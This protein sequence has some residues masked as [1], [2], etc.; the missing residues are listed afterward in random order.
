MQGKSVQAH[1]VGKV[2]EILEAVSSAEWVGEAAG[3]LSVIAARARAAVVVPAVKAAVAVCLAMSVILVV[4]KLSMAAV[5]MLVK[6]LKRKP[7]KVYEWRPISE[8]VEMGGSLA[9]P[10]VLVQIPMY[11]E[12]EVYHLSI[13]AACALEWPSDRLIVQVLDDS[14][15]PAIQDLV[16][17]ECQRW[18]AKGVNIYYKTRDS[19]KGYKAGALKEGMDQD[20]VKKCDYVAIFD[21]D[22][23]PPT[24][25]LV[26]T[27]PFLVRNPKIALVQAR[28][29]FVN[30][31]DCI[32]T[33][34]QEMSLNYHFKV[35]QE[36]GSSLVA[37]FGFNG[38]AGIWRI[39]ALMDAEGWKE[40]TTV[41]DMDLAV[42]AT[43]KGWKFVYVGDLKVKSELP[44]TYTAY[45]YQ[46]HRWACGPANLCR[47]M[48]FD[49]IK[50]KIVSKK[51]DI[52]SFNMGIECACLEE[53]LSDLQLLFRSKARV[54]QCYFFI[55]LRGDSNL[56]FLPEVE[57]PR[58]GVIYI[59]TIITLLN[60]FT[61]PRSIHLILIWV[62][63]ENVMSLHRFI[64]VYVGLF[65]AGRVN[66]WVVTEKLG[67]TLNA[68]PV[69]DGRK[70]FHKFWKR[71]HFLEL[72]IGVFLLLCASYDLTCRAQRGELP[73]IPH[74]RDAFMAQWRAVTLAMVVVVLCSS[75]AA[76]AYAAAGESNG[77]SNGV[78]LG[79]LLDQ[80]ILLPS[81]DLV[82]NASRLLQQSI[83]RCVES[84]YRSL[85]EVSLDR[86]GVI[87]R[88]VRSRAIAPV[89]SVA[90]ALCMVMS[91]MLVF[92]AAYM[93]AV[94]LGV[95]LL[96]RKPEKRYKWE[97]IEGDEEKGSLAFP[98]VLVQIPMYNEKE[99]YKLSIR[100]ACALTWPPDR[101][102][103]Q[104]LD[105]STDPL[106]KDMVELE[107]KAWASK[108]I[109]I[110]YEVRSNRK[111]MLLTW[112]FPGDFAVNYDVCLM[113]RIQKISLDYHFKVEQE[114]GSS[115]YAFFGFNGTAGVWRMSAINEAGG[116]KDRTTVED[117]DLA[118]RA[119]LK[120]WK[121]LYDGD[122]TVKS[123]LPSTF[124]AY[125]HQQHRWTCGA[126][127]L[128]RK[129]AWNIAINKEV[130][131]WKKLHVLYSFF[132]VRRVIAPLVTFTFYCIVIPISSLVPEVSIPIWG[133]SIFLQQLPFSMP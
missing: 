8:D 45:R 47:K 16:Q 74:Q 131:L 54:V 44:S 23:Q 105:D 1:L 6:I 85:D 127:N 34:I 104:V 50:A 84:I 75:A 13:G 76:A 56:M 3:R 14:T 132:F 91:F 80:P 68:Q 37:F 83:A 41:E 77:E 117:M 70:R 101:I 46:Q 100:A 15:D 103:I 39:Q 10:M 89:L 62:F 114:S 116:W 43:L 90:V 65:E 112:P 67:D 115:T 94:S 55:L 29:K 36:S 124:K 18:L 53:V 32:M 49:I 111:G 86:V 93:S 78:Y 64:A 19:R 69:V 25:F 125:R 48:A 12:K 121:L 79:S 82:V 42:R 87:W 30:V 58:W 81:S 96:R 26:R 57:I 130:S 11:N 60:S 51:K 88:E 102:I 129:M 33:R 35:E 22:H 133:C 59:P 118:V 27:V 5:S 128:F 72:G 40:R 31:N 52:K 123:E 61:T 4:E 73:L 24:D 28:W 97:P 95:K 122:I 21:A 99:V 106:I 120:G 17:I 109:N 66:E 110:K 98:M 108:Q 38:T 113:T 2:A 63:F 107:C 7:E 71:F 20:Y 92:E 119:T 126:A 9:Y